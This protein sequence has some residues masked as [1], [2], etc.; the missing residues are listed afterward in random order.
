ML[1]LVATIIAVSKAS[2]RNEK[3]KMKNEKLKMRDVRC[4]V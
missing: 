1:R 4:Y 2:Q 3:F